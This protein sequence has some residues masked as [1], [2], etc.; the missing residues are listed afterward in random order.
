MT[1]F[2]SDTD[3][4]VN[5]I[6][7]NQSTGVASG[8]RS[9]EASPVVNQRNPRPDITSTTGPSILQLN[10]EGLTRAKLEVIQHLCIQHSISILA[11][12]EIHS[13]CDADIKL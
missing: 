10:V 12:Q 2:H 6:D 4:D 1:D 13:K 3:N 9:C 5:G 11:L 8:R 7:G